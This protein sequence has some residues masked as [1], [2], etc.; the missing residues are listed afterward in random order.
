MGAL[1]YLSAL[2]RQVEERKKAPER[3]LIH[4][5]RSPFKGEGH[6]TF[7]IRD[8]GK[9]ARIKMG[10]GLRPLSSSEL[11]CITNDGDSPTSAHEAWSME[12]VFNSHS[13]SYGRLLS[14]LGHGV[15]TC[16]KSHSNPHRHLSHNILERAFSQN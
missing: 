1:R 2:K 6:P 8:G 9:E 12:R 13:C 5:C 7:H 11:C 3:G 4:V 10:A 14:D 16:S 15:F